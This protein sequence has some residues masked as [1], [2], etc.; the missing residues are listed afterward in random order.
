MKLRHKNW[1]WGKYILEG[2]YLNSC[3]IT[4]NEPDFEEYI[5][6]KHGWHNSEEYKNEKLPRI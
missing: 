2:Q 1:Y 6:E 5:E 3:R 4:R